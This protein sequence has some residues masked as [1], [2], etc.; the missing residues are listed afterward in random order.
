MR[1]FPFIGLVCLAFL[2]IYAT[3]SAADEGNSIRVIVKPA[4]HSRSTNLH[5]N[6]GISAKT[7]R[8]VASS[9]DR[10]YFRP[11]S[12]GRFDIPIRP[13]FVPRPRRIQKCKPPVQ[14]C[15][16]PLCPPPV[17]FCPLCFLPRRLPGQWELQTQFFFA[18]VG[19][20]VR[21]PA[22]SFGVTTS[23]VDF[24]SQLG[25]DGHNTFYEFTARYQFRPR[26][27]IHYSIMPYETDN[28]S[29]VGDPFYF[30]IW[31][32][33]TGTALHTKWDFVYQRLGLI[34]QPI[35]TPQA[36][37]SLF[38]YWL[39]NDQKLQLG[40]SMC[41]G[42]CSTLDRSRNMIMSGIEIQKC[43]KTLPNGLTFSC[44]NRFGIGY[45]DNTLVLDIQTGGQLTIPFFPGRWGYVKG[46]YRFI[47]FQEDRV[48]LMWDNVLEGGFVEVGLIF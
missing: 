31:N 4:K 10:V 38:N 27:A 35:V 26:W 12:F 41:F 43:I 7:L 14:K 42:Q 19:G 22:T 45:L 40:S 48:D 23:D 34:Y 8:A 3:A 25:V 13:G 46:G 20:S 37:V 6:A 33:T 39:Y 32:F 2:L 15:K 29:T 36:I 17:P 47:K 21:W 44:D 30:G 24:T 1:R 18:R 28:S 9:R 11:A 16:A 5:P